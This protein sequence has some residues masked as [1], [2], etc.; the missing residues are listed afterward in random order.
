VDGRAIGINPEVPMPAKTSSKPALPSAAPRAGSWRCRPNGSR[1]LLRAVFLRRSA[2]VRAQSTC[3][4]QMSSPRP[5][6]RPGERPRNSPVNGPVNGP[7][8]SQV[9]S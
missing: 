4:V 5:N 7:V 9:D 8:N 2:V 1:T 6:Q 3:P